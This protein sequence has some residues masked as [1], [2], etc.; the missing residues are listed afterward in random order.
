MFFNSEDIKAKNETLYK[1]INFS[2]LPAEMEN[3][4]MDNDYMNHIKLYKLSP[5]LKYYEEFLRTHMQVTTRTVHIID[6]NDVIAYMMRN[7]NLKVPMTEELEMA[8]AHFDKLACPNS[9]EAMA[10]IIYEQLKIEK[11]IDYITTINH[12]KVH[13]EKIMK[14]ITVVKS[15]FKMYK[16]LLAKKFLFVDGKQRAIEI[17][18]GKLFNELPFHLQYELA[19]MEEIDLNTLLCRPILFCIIYKKLHPD[20]IFPKELSFRH[21]YLILL[22]GLLL[23]IIGL[24]IGKNPDRETVLA[25]CKEYSKITPYPENSLS[26][27]CL[28]S[29]ES[30]KLKIS[31]IDALRIYD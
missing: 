12:L 26:Q 31:C 21:P 29:M 11:Q 13:K 8:L 20:V 30:L 5:F 2:L 14:E 24:I 17:K 28:E 9:P 6:Y 25:R 18:L 22:R 4:F 27:K 3:A 7:S 15:F 19:R 10:A 16:P 1:N 23:E